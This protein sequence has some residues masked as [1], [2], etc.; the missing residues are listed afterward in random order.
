MRACVC[1][2]SSAEPICL[3][4]MPDKQKHKGK[5]I[6]KK[7]LI[8]RQKAMTGMA[9]A[10]KNRNAEMSKCEVMSACQGSRIV[11]VSELVKNLFCSKKID[12]LAV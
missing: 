11:D 1:T 7:V 8:K 4:K 9:Q 3:I 12:N 10:K 6:K 5:W 2:L